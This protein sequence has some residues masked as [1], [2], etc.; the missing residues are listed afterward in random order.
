MQKLDSHWLKLSSLFLAAVH[1]DFGVSLL[2]L[3]GN[4]L[5][6]IFNYFPLLNDCV[7]IDRSRAE[8]IY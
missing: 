3:D 4:N 2:T 1:V 6:F 8:L 7:Y 5:L